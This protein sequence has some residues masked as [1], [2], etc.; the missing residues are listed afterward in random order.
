[1]FIEELQEAMNMTGAG[2]NHHSYGS[3]ASEDNESAAKIPPRKKLS[4]LPFV[5][6]VYYEVSGSAFGIEPIVKAGGP[7][8]A[9]LGFLLMLVIER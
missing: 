5:F 3:L 8:L 2:A 6:L 1:M 4:L 9:L 7:L